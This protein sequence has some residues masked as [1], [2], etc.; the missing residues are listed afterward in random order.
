MQTAY[1]KPTQIH[2]KYLDDDT[3]EEEGRERHTDH[4]EYRDGIVEFSVLIASALDTQGNGDNQLQN[5]RHK[6]DCEGYAHVVE[7]LLPY[8]LV[9]NEGFTKIALQNAPEP[10]AV[11]L[12]DSP[13]G[14]VVQAVHFKEAIKLFLAGIRLTV[15]YIIL[16]SNVVNRHQSYQEVQKDGY[17]QQNEQGNQDSFDDIFCHFVAFFLTEPRP[18]VRNRPPT[19]ARFVYSLIFPIRALPC[20]FCADRKILCRGRR[21]LPFHK[22]NFFTHT[23]TCAPLIYY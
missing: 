4:G 21:S 16:I 3:A 10:S 23:R 9:V 11:A 6:R 19:L 8:G 18:C 14:I 15:R 22:L 1:L 20:G 17:P 13:E 7:N 5:E 12:D 2:R